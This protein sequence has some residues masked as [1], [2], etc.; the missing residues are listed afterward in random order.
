MSMIEVT[1][2][3][4]ELPLHGKFIIVHEDYKVIVDD[5][6]YLIPAGSQ[7]DGASIPKL[8][9]RVVGSPL[10]GPYR[11]QAILHDAL[12]RQYA[13]I[14]GLHIGINPI[15]RKDADIAFNIAMKGHVHWLRRQ[16]IYR[17]VR[18]GGASSWQGPKP[19]PNQWRC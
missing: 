18:M 13:T 8:L 7:S 12:Y 15:N 17:G 6:L 9:W 5:H 1:P 3:I 4:A 19:A 11:N 10:T 14:D 16:A 2:L